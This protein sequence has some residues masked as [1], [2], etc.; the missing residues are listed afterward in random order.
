MSAT[1][2]R[3][4]KAKAPRKASAHRPRKRVTPLP[5]KAPE[6]LVGIPSEAVHEP[7]P[8]EIP[9]KTFLVAIRIKG[10]FGTPSEAE[11]LLNSLRLKKKF[12]AVLFDNN[13]IVLGAL[14]QA[15]DYLTFGE[16]RSTQ[17]TSLL[18]LRGKLHGHPKL[19]D[20]S[21]QEMLGPKSVDELVASLAQGN[22]TLN[23]LWS[24]GLKPVFR[25][26]PPSGGFEGSTKRP[27][28]SG[29]ELG[30]R[31]TAISSLITRM[32]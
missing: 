13:P 1:Q 19:T 10:E 28:H 16:I 18:R 8:K 9:E 21:V 7:P 11:H 27:Y 6:K 32:M 30:Y 2:K 17:L 12:N 4:A 25:L 23:S 14:R 26:R 29:G 5:K 3:K 15:K 24:K 20:K 31:G 22:L